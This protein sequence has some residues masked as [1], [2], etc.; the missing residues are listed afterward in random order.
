M[1]ELK[2]VSVKRRS[3]LAGAG[4]GSALLGASAVIGTVG[5]GSA[6]AQDKGSEKNS[7]MLVGRGI[8]DVTGEPLGA[9][10][11]GYGVPEQTSVG[12][13]LRQRAR[14]FVFVS[15]E[16][17]NRV[18]HVTVEVGLMFQSIF[19]EVIRRLEAKFGGIY[20]SGNVLLTATHTHSAPGGT[21]GHLL[22]DIT[23]LGF[24]PVTFESNVSGIVD[25][26]SRAHDDIAPSEVSLTQ[27]S[28]HDASANRSIESFN[29][30]PDED[31]AFF[32]DAIDPSSVNLQVSRNGKL[33]GVL[34]WF[35]THG[36]SL[37]P[38]NRLASTDNK[39]YA[40]WHWEHVVKGVD[41][42]S[43]D[44]S[45]IS[46][47]AQSTPGD[48]S[49]NLW[50]R[51]GQG[52][53]DNEFENT[54]IIGERQS[55][56]AQNQVSFAAINLDS[57]IDF[58]WTYIDMR[59]YEVTP[60]FTGD[61][62][63]HWTAPAMLGAAFAATSQ[64]DGGG[65]DGL[66]LN[67]GSRGGSPIFA[68]LANVLV[69]QW[70][71][72]AHAPK[73]IMLPIGAIPGFGQEILPFYLSKIG[74]LYLFSSSFEPT[75]VAGLRIKRALSSALGV[76]LDRIIIQGYTN[77]YGHYITTRE[78]YNMQNYEG[79][80]TQF[81]PWSLAAVTQ[82]AVNLARDLIAGR[83]NDPGTT[84]RDL[85]GVIPASPLGMSVVDIPSP[86]TQFGDV[87]VAPEGS[88]FTGDQVS[89]S[90]SGAN[91]NNNLRRYDTYLLV[92]K[93]EGSQWRAVH[94]DSDW[95]TKIYFDVLGPINT[96]RIT[97]DIPGDTAAGTYR[98]R[99]FGDAKSITGALTPIFGESP[100][101]AVS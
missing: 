80:A 39:G 88:Y 98:I 58:R 5:A 24:R 67:E 25:A 49:A 14:A 74:G 60:E 45:F 69:P 18:A 63:T 36:T 75:I 6:Q 13:H 10:M 35:A 26:I 72:D 92:E 8:G 57:T 81:G 33:V 20:H 94:D 4:A 71:K 87:L 46:A 76:P 91:P 31:R 54:R 3:L 93:Q 86:G 99:Y 78:E 85:T 41:Y 42:R 29:A 12:M 61:G 37:T 101:F 40:A 84:D 66:P 15:P 77:G 30:D 82:I 51:P 19:E 62:L 16:S 100:T 64:E 56:T 7:R 9:G 2:K 34:N 1:E 11:N 23:T 48:V 79:G 44:N 70:L 21:D 65:L 97:W 47:F 95:S 38:K 28:L 32:P 53:T 73:D 68:A 90:F 27:G 43:D 89:V 96:C 22:V 17:G 59:N 52:P 55:I 83:P 50:L